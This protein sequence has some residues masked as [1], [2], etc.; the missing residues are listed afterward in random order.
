M[1]LAALL[2]DVGKLRLPPHILGKPGR[3]TED[4]RRWCGC[5]RSG[6]PRWS[7]ASLVW[8]RLP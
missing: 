7:V 1:E 6:A 5:T 3:L 4:E 8:R 2:H